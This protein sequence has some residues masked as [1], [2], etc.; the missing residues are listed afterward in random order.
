MRSSVTRAFSKSALRLFD[1]GAGHGDFLRAGAVRQLRQV[2]FQIGELAFHLIELGAVFVV[3][4][5]HDDLVLFHLVALFHADPE[6]FADHFRG[7]FDL[8]MRRRCTRW[9]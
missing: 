9:R 2:R 4:Q 5:A 3:F 7:H 8:V 1:I 6:H